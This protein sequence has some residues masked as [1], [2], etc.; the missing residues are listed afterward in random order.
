[1]KQIRVVPSAVEKRKPV[2]DQ[3]SWRRNGGLLGS[4]LDDG[5][6]F[7]GENLGEGTTVAGMADPDWIGG[8]LVHGAHAR[9]IRLVLVHGLDWGISSVE[10]PHWQLQVQKPSTSG[11]PLLSGGSGGQC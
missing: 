4:D 2:E 1:M 6:D 11:C 5:P 9:E 3:V 10:P 7:G 8:D